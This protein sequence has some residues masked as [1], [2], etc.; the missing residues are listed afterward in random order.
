MHYPM[1]RK[2][3]VP[4][5][6]SKPAENA[7][8][9]AVA[10]AS[11]FSGRSEIILLNVVQEVVLPPVLI[12]SPRLRSRLTGDEITTAGLV[13]ELC[14]HLKEEAAKMLNDKRQ[15]ILA[16]T[17]DIEVQKKGARRLSFREDNRICRGRIC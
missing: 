14:Q 3:L 8:K 15:Q 7:L 17:K 12:G 11:N 6:G 16:K 10:L 2:I 9:H 1:F 4:Y 5:D 13:K